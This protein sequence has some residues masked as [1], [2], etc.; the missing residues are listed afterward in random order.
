MR[1]A[2]FRAW[3][4]HLAVAIREAQAALQ[5]ADEETFQDV[6]RR[7]EFILVR[8][9]RERLASAVEL[10]VPDSLRPLERT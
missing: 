6:L 7:K 9:A 5:S 1:S 4:S 8:S 2:D 10:M 3:Q